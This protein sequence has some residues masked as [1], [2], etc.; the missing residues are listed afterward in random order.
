MGKKTGEEEKKE[1]KGTV[2]IC[3][4]MKR[5]EN[6]GEEIKGEK[7]REETLTQEKEREKKTKSKAVELVR[8][9]TN[10]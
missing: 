1:R 5:V 4:E 6:R 10:E 2:W 8:R 3:Y 9:R 7:T